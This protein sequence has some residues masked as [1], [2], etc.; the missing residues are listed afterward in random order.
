MN[1]QL[2]YPFF[3]EFD[4]PVELDE[5]EHLL[6]NDDNAANRSWNFEVLSDKFLHL[7]VNASPFSHIPANEHLSRQLLMAAES[8]IWDALG[9][10]RDQHGHTPFHARDKI[11]QELRAK[12]STRHTAFTGTEMQ[13][14]T[15]RAMEIEIDCSPTA[16]SSLDGSSTNGST[17]FSA[18][19][20]PED[21]TITSHEP[22]QFAEDQVNP[23]AGTH[24]DTDNPPVRDGTVPWREF[25]A[26]ESL[27]KQLPRDIMDFGSQMPDP[28]SQFTS[29]NDESGEDLERGNV[30]HEID[31]P[32][33][34]GGYISGPIQQPTGAGSISLER[35][36]ISTCEDDIDEMLENLNNLPDDPY[37]KLMPDT[38]WFDF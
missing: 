19:N 7:A 20:G 27:I 1:L 26:S 32:H 3:E 11:R 33:S 30:C 23:P 6:Y 37:Q 34:A 2:I 8:H 13:H 4:P 14:E 22:S 36:N 25:P 24:Q 18:V 5:A 12:I 17:V 16:R 15:Q 29:S 31:L 10:L 9:G 38:R 28:A 35:Q 21:N